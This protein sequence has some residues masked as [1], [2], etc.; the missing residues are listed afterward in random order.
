MLLVFR[1]MFGFVGFSMGCLDSVGLWLDLD[2][3]FLFATWY[4]VK[5]VRACGP[6]NI[7]LPNRAFFSPNGNNPVLKCL[8]LTHLLSQQG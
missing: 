1:W 6:C 5:V 7:T 8:H 3:V 2:L 4:D